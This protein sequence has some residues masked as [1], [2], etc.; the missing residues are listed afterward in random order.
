ML[1]DWTHDT[2][3]DGCYTFGSDVYQFGVM[4]GK[5]LKHT[6]QDVPSDATSLLQVLKSKISAHKALQH[7]WLKI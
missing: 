6:S 5:L 4:L 2:L 7:A 1:T 3:D